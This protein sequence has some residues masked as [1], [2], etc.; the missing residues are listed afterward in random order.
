MTQRLGTAAVL[1]KAYGR[2]PLFSFSQQVMFEVLIAH[3]A[4]SNGD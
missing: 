2:K 3:I 1:E 4:V